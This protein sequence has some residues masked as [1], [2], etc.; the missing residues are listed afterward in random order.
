MESVYL[1]IGMAVVTFSIRY[2][3]LPLSGRIRF[4]DR[5]QRALHYVPSAVLTAIIVPA[6]LM[7]NG[8]TLDFS[9]NNAY[10]VGAVATV[11][12]GKAGGNLLITIIGGMVFF[13]LWQWGVTL[14]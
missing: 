9:W 1:I 3:L 11:V 8:V 5:M 13:A 12:I 6:V 2:V 4:S 7:P 10:L 14:F